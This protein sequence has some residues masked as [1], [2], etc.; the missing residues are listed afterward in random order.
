MNF[1]KA[2]RNINRSITKKQPETFNSQWIKNRCKV[3]YQFIIHNTKTEF[4]E[5]DWDLI[6]SKLGKHNQRKWMKGI[7]RNEVELYKNQN[8]IN[9]VLNK[10]NDKLYTFLGQAKKE[11]RITC[12]WISMRLARIAQKGN[13]LA[14][15][16]LISLVGQLVDSWIEYDKCLFA[17]KG[18]DE[19][20]IKQIKGCIR[21]FRYAGSFLGYLHT[22][23]ER[24]GRGLIPLEKFS[25][26]DY[27][28]V[29]EK[30][31]IETFVKK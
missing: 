23:L 13:V 24:S 20:I 12:D 10:Y 19:L 21:R 8:E 15:E 30:R 27:H 18:Y 2:I 14:Q 17:W 9:L 7:K 16:E 3:S 22:T 29:T 28:P 4:N 31:I 11:D 26:D 25:L 1:E 5:P 6:V